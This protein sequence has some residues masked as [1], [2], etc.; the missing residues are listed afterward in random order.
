M[1]QVNVSAPGQKRRKA[2]TAFYERQNSLI[3][4]LLEA[5]AVHRQVISRGDGGGGLWTSHRMRM[6][7]HCT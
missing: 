3:N 2:T 6:D 5:E 4:H 7:L 1:P